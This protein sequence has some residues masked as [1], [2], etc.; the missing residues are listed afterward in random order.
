MLEQGGKRSFR[1]ILVKNQ[2]SKDKAKNPKV[3]GVGG[4]G[5]RKDI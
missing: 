1:A 5:H 2:N 4:G 3:G